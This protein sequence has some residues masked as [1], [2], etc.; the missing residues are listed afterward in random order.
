M[1]RREEE[2]CRRI[3]TPIRQT[4]KEEPDLKSKNIDLIAWAQSGVLSHFSGGVKGDV[5]FL[6]ARALRSVEPTV[7]RVGVFVCVCR[8]RKMMQSSEAIQ[9]CVCVFVCVCACVTFI[10]LFIYLFWSA[11]SGVP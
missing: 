1:K 4:P 5:Y 6:L 9:L 7:V 3:Q 2:R 11:F 8:S 10:Y